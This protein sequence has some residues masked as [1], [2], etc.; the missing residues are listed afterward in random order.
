MSEAEPEELNSIK[1][2]QAKLMQTERTTRER[3]RKKE[4]AREFGRIA[5]VYLAG[6]LRYFTRHANLQQV[7][8]KCM[9]LSSRQIC[10]G[11]VTTTIAGTVFLQ[12]S[13]LSKSQP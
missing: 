9:Q 8:K 12:D 11:L 2:L 1:V 10:P 5:R 4:G 6:I 3:E 13:K 7:G